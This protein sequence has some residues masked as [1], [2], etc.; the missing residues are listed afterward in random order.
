M[1]KTVGVRPVRGVCHIMYVGGNSR[2]SIHNIPS[3]PAL[4]NSEFVVSFSSSNS[5]HVQMHTPIF[6][7]VV[8]FNSYGQR[9]VGMAPPRPS[10][11]RVGSCARTVQKRICVSAY[12][13]GCS[14]N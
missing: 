14:A 2:F 13:K 12:A 1:S 9:S 11:R 7:K 5:D 6:P 4:D 10:E 3:Y 8:V